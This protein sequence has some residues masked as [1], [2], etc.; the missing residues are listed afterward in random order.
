[1]LFS[2]GSHAQLYVK[3]FMLLLEKFSCPATKA[4]AIAVVK[5]S[6]ILPVACNLIERSLSIII[7]V[8]STGVAVVDSVGNVASSQSVGCLGLFV[9]FHFGTGGVHSIN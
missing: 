6:A 4:P 9:L 3:L 5:M 2:S 7:W 8:V 1:M